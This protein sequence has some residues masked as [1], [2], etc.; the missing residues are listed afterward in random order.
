MDN[1]A[2]LNQ[3]SCLLLFWGKERHPWVPV[4]ERGCSQYTSSYLQLLH[5]DLLHKMRRIRQNWFQG[6]RLKV[7]RGSVSVYFY[8]WVGFSREDSFPMDPEFY[9]AAKKAWFRTI[10]EVYCWWANPSLAL[11]TEALQSW[12]SRKPAQPPVCSFSMACHIM[13]PERGGADTRVDQRWKSTWGFQIVVFFFWTV[14]FLVFKRNKQF[15]TVKSAYECGVV[16]KCCVSIY[17]SCMLTTWGRRTAY[18]TT[19]QTNRIF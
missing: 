5:Q 2:R 16:E 10:Q 18:T 6:C 14:D 3:E 9:R 19:N 11:Q 1:T 4:G 12:T 17:L 8:V 15:V 7:L 13:K